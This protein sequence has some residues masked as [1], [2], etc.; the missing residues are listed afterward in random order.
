MT[1][2]YQSQ[3]V[4]YLDKQVLKASSKS[5]QDIEMWL[6]KVVLFNLWRFNFKQIC[7]KEDSFKKIA[8]I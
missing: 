7:L 1:D 5:E 6:N 3:S 2:N 8:K 4:G